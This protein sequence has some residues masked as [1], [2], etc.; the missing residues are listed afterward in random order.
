MRRAD[1]LG[2]KRE[3]TDSVSE[4]FKVFADGREPELFPRRDVLNDR[5]TRTEL[6][7]DA[8]IFEPESGSRIRKASPFASG[9]IALAGEPSA[10]E[11]AGREV[12]GANG[13]DVFESCDMW[14]VFLQ[15]S[16]TEFVDLH[17][18]N[19]ARAANGADQS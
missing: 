6:S 19:D 8:P 1:V 16:V 17:L 18:G 13:S 10:D 11:I 9:T 12:V 15:D 4:P 7:E 2:R 14:K 5:E 3:G